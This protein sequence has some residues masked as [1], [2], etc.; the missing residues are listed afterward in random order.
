MCD[1][2]EQRLVCPPGTAGS[3]VQP[4]VKVRNDYCMRYIPS[5]SNVGSV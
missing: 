4:S 3:G 5:D 2:T 1:E